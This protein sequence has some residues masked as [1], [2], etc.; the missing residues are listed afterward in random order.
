M[1]ILITGVSSGF[2]LEMAK[3]LSQ[4]GHTIY[5][6]VRRDVEHIA[7]VNYLNADVR[8]EESVIKAVEEVIRREGFIDVLINNAGMGVGG[9]I[10]FTST[11]D[12][13]N[14]M[15]VNFFGL[16]RFV[17]AVLP[18]MRKRGS[19]KIIAMSSIGGLMGLPYQGFYSAGK[20]AVEGY[21]ESLRLETRKF[22]IKV[23]VIEPGDF[24]TGFTASRKKVGSCSDELA[25]AYPGY[26]KSM[27]SIEKDEKGGLTPDVLAKRIAK[28]VEKKNPAYNYIIAT[29]VQKISVFI[30]KIVSA[31]TYSK[32]L[33]A[34]Y[35]L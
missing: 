33:G 6:T 7:G 26:A 15:D 4:K 3:I 24:S 28:I 22:G 13:M 18:Y 27:E 35:K 34:Y 32:I 1:V 23:V 10:E 5:G 20:F 17:H 9:P 2:G 30:K 11:A 21:C 29:F 12:A 14:Q 16:V 31:R 19:G 8:D 25:K